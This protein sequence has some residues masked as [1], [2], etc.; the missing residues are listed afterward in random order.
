[1]AW[2]RKDMKG[3]KGIYRK[4][5][6]TAKYKIGFKTVKTTEEK[7]IKEWKANNP[8]PPM[9]ENHLVPKFDLFT[10]NYKFGDNPNRV[11]ATILTI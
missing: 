10:W 9:G 1:M 6:V 4:K 8:A 11:E 2:K 3:D 7:E 5:E